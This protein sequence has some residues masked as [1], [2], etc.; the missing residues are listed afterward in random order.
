MFTGIIEHMGRVASAESGRAGMRL[1][2]ESRGWLQDPRLGESISIDGCCLTL[3]EADGAVLQFDV[4]PLTLQ[5]TTLGRLRA[6]AIVNLERSATLSTLLGGHLVQGH[7]D[8]VGRI[9]CVVVAAG[10]RRLHITAPLEVSPFLVPRGSIAVNGVSLTVAEVEAGAGE[11]VGAVLGSAGGRGGAGGA[12]SASGTD[13]SRF[14]VALIP[15]TLAR[16]NLGA[17]REG[18]EVNLEADAIAKLVDASVRRAL[19]RRSHG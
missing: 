19:E 2:V 6:G 16:T 3:A 14:K 9:E 7:V 1:V 8:G 10:E 4:V 18:D 15:E 5:R 13:C 11:E 17:L 12:I